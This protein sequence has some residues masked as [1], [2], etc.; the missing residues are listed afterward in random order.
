MRL[1][2][3]S[4]SVIPSGTANSVQVMKMCRAFADAGCDVVL[5]G[6]CGNGSDPW[7]AYGIKPEAFE[8]KLWTPRRAWPYGTYTWWLRQQMRTLPKPQVVYGRFPFGL[9]CVPQNVVRFYEVHHPPESAKSWIAERILFR[10]RRFLG[11]V[12]I[13]DA[14]QRNYEKQSIIRG[15]EVSVLTAH[16]GA[17]CISVNRSDCARPAEDTPSLRCLYSGSLYA[18]KGG[19]FLSRLA[20]TLSHTDIVIRIVGGKGAPPGLVEEFRRLRN[21]EYIG[22]VPHG[23]VNEHLAKADIA[24]APYQKHVVIADMAIDLAEWMSPLKL[25]EYMAA[26]V[27]IIASDLPVIREVLVD[28]ETARLVESDDVQAWV[29]AIVDLAQRPDERLRLADAAKRLL[30]EKYSWQ[31]RARR[32]IKW[33]DE[34]IASF[35]DRG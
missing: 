16:D 11:L 6:R 7:G 35:E 2:Y 18:G 12:A 28:A 17:D 29:D 25:F 30:A 5:F 1:Y 23:E 19:E 34:R 31:V 8:I 15:R 9:A 22:Q 4:N 33:M 24:L 26:G 14:L 32:I 3:I 21:V 13:S 10:Q 27:P 20:K